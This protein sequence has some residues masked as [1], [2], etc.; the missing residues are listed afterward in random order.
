VHERLRPG[1][2]PGRA[3]LDQVAGQRE[4]RS[5]EPDQRGAGKLAG[6]HP[7]RLVDV[8]DLARV[9]VRQPGHVGRGTHRRG[10][11]RPHPGHDVQVD[12]G[13]PQRHHDVGEQDRRVHPVPA[14]RLQ[15]D[16][17]DE[18]RPG[19]GVEHADPGPDRPVL[20]Q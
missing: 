5:G 8:P 13:R 2:V 15:G 19:A 17:G 9:E 1:V 20:R 12:A 3:A 10:D 11:H 14:H 7:D 18:V 16:L 4:R 6:E